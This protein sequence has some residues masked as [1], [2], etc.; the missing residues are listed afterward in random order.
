MSYC[1]NCGVELAASLE[2]CPLC[3]TRVVNP[4]EREPGAEAPSFPPEMPRYTVPQIR[5]AAA[6]SVAVLLLIPLFSTLVCDSVF[7]GALTWSR[8]VCAG[9]LILYGFLFPPLFVSRHKVTLCMA[10]GWLAL[11]AALWVFCSITGGAWFWRFALPLVTGSFLLAYAAYLLVRHTPWN[12]LKTGAAVLGSLG[13][14]TLYVEWL[15]NSAFFGGKSL[16]WSL[17]TVVPCLVLSAFLALVDSNRAL[18]E[19]I[20]RRF[21]F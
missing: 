7:N 21:F 19:S 3:G 9:Y 4:A 12:F 16:V 20:R 14:F 10:I 18:K 11:S 13:F 5:R 15:I 1:V 8:F 17:I 2:R 6:L